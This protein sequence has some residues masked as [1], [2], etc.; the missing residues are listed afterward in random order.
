VLGAADP[1][2]VEAE[3]LQ[4]LVREAEGFADT[5]GLGLVPT[6]EQECWI[7]VP[8]HDPRAVGTAAKGGQRGVGGAPIE[9]RQFLFAVAIALI[10]LGALL[11]TFWPQLRPRTAPVALVGTPGALTTTVTP[12][13]SLDVG[14]EIQVWY[15]SSLELPRDAGDLV[16]RAAAVPGA[17]GGNWAPE[18]ESGVA[19]WLEGTYGPAHMTVDIFGKKYFPRIWPAVVVL[20]PDVVPAYGAILPLTPLLCLPTAVPPS[21]DGRQ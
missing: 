11:W 21:P 12:V 14:S 1:Y 16:L 8:D 3:L 9:R 2:A 20:C 7:E 13:D 19:A 10:G 5:E 4:T 17:L 15:P 6:A 18:L